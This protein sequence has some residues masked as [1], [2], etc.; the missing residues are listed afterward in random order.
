MLVY[1]RVIPIIIPIYHQMLEIA[2]VSLGG[3]QADV[4]ASTV[5]PGGAAN[6]RWRSIPRLMICWEI[7]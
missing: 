5:K 6:V 1:Q 3:N 4:A 2:E 7:H